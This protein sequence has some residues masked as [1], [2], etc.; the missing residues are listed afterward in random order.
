[1]G[2]RSTKEAPSSFDWMSDGEPLSCGD[3]KPALSSALIPARAAS[4]SN[5]LEANDSVNLELV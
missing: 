5:S 4:T 2:A 1:M 3:T